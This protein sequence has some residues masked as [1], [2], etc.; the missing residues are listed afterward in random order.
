[1][2]PQESYK[3]R[4]VVA[5]EDDPHVLDLIRTILES[6][7]FVVSGATTGQEGIR[8]MAEFMGELQ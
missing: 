1:M 5:V 6:A 2:N 7:G 3:G 4:R 8:R